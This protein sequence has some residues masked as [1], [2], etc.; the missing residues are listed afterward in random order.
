MMPVISDTESPRPRARTSLRPGRRASAAAL[1]R[2]AHERRRSGPVG[3]FAPDRRGELRGLAV[4]ARQPD[5]SATARAS[6]RGSSW[7]SLNLASKRSISSSK[8]TMPGS[9]RVISECGIS[10]MRQP[11]G[12]GASILSLRIAS[13]RSRSAVGLLPDA[14]VAVNGGVVEGARHLPL[15]VPGRRDVARRAVEDG[16]RRRRR[17]RTARGRG[18]W[19]GR[20]ARAAR[21]ARRATGRAAAAGWWRKVRRRRC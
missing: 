12:I 21:R 2:R 14:T 6:P 5:A 11:S 1:A 4:R 3:V 18:R 20:G 17:R 9:R 7:P 15:R 16:E 10:S 8:P 13:V 19:R